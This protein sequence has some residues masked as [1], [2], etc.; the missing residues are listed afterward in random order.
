MKKNGWKIFTAF[1]AG[2]TLVIS[3]CTKDVYTQK[4]SD[5]HD[6]NNYRTYAW[7]PSGDTVYNDF[8]KDSKVAQQ[9]RN[10]INKELG[11]VGYVVNTEDPDFLV[12]VHTNYERGVEL[13]KMPNNYMFYGPNFD[14]GIWYENYYPSYQDLTYIDGPA[15][16]T[17][18][19]TAGT[20]VIDLI[21]KRTKEIVWRGVANDKIYDDRV[22]EE[23]ADEISEIF[24]EFPV[25]RIDN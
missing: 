25:S 17:V 13:E 7:L 5:N 3:A 14:A 10:E 2:L 11:E 22:A 15:V 23:M 4:L 21:D 6:L 12:L 19:Y 9:I 20:L 1:I 8:N 24:A 18:P 16:S